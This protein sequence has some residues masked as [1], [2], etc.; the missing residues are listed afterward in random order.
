M[1]KQKNYDGWE[2][3]SFDDAYNFR[4]FQIQKI[5]KYIKKKK[6]LDVGSGTGGLVN[7]YLEETN[8]VSAIEPTLKLKKILEDKF[9]FLVNYIYYFI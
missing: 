3:S 4:K 2:L 5:E 1:T 9:K 8:K 7:Y 6:I